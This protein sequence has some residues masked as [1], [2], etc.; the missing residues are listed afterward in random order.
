LAAGWKLQTIDE[1]AA[2]IL[3]LVEPN[4]ENDMDAWM[5]WFDKIKDII[6]M[7]EQ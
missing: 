6:T 3:T 2:K 1:P 5:A 4:L 7:L